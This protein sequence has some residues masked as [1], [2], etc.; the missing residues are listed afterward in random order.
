MDLNKSRFHFIRG[1]VACAGFCALL[2]SCGNVSSNVSYDY[3][4][5]TAVDFKNSQI[6]S[7]GPQAADGATNLLVVISLLNSNNTPVVGFTPT[8]EIVSGLGVTASPCTSSNSNGV[9]TCILRSAQTGIKRLRVTNVTTIAL[10]ADVT[11]SAPSGVK[12][13]FDMS[14]ASS[15]K[16]SG[17][18][19]SFI[20]TVGGLKGQKI[21]NSGYSFFG[22]VQGGVFAQ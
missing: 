16:M 22:G 1:L 8:Y 13:R 2:A 19:Y 3:T 7:N 6:I 15:G 14:L 20:G 4:R 18:A 9:S 12:S 11:F 21:S 17:G 10:S 5:T